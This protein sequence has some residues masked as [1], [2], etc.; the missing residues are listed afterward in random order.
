MKEKAITPPSPEAEKELHDIVHNV[1]TEVKVRDTTFRVGGI[2]NDTLDKITSI[3]IDADA[4]EREESRN[5][6]KMSQSERE[7]LERSR[8]VRERKVTAKCAA[9]IVLNGFFRIRLLWW[10]VW[11]WFFYVRQYTDEEFAPL[12]VELKKKAASERTAFLVNTTF[13]IDVRTTTMTMTRKEASRIRQEL[14]TDGLGRQQSLRKG[15]SSFRTSSNPD[16]SSSDS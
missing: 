11:R 5:E 14:I 3:L 16:D 6:E 2:Y 1:K 8:F 10:L 4:A 15:A 9:A 7:H 13:L 12:I